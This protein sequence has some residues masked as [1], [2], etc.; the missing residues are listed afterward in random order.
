MRNIKVKK[1]IKLQCMKQT[2]KHK[3]LN[4]KNKI[5]NFKHTLKKTMSI[6]IIKKN[7]N[8]VILY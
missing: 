2:K 7:K 6:K 1:I 8:K 5:I 4:Y 3:G